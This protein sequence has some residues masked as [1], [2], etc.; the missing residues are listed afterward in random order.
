VFVYTY[1]LKISTDQLER[2]I[3]SRDPGADI[4]SPSPFLFT[5]RNKTCDSNSCEASDWLGRQK[6][7][8]VPPRGLGEFRF[9]CDC[10][11]PKRVKSHPIG[12]GQAS[13]LIR[14]SFCSGLPLRL[15][16]LTVAVINLKTWRGW[17]CNEDSS[18]RL[19]FG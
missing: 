9:V 5:G 7:N 10:F 19:R 13:R 16:K 15:A 14:L 6:E 4:D 11:P 8:K 18:V 2:D 3:L 17:S 1:L 12:A